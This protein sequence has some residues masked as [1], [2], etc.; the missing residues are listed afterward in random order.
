MSIKISSQ[1]DAGA[2]EVVS[3]TSA[4]AIDLNIRKDSHADIIQW[5]YFRLQGARGQACTI[6]LLN[7]GQSAYPKGW[8]DYQAMASYDRVNWFRVPTSFDGQVHDHRAHA[9]PWTASTTPI[10]SPIRGSATWSCSTAPSCPSR[11]ACSTS[12]RPSTAA[13]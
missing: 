3:A 6:R 2:I 4:D 9:R 10:S 8:E 12:A 13:T 7:A 5:F 1:F 11:C